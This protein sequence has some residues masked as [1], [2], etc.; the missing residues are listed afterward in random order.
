MFA[1]IDDCRRPAGR[2]RRVED[3]RPFGSVIGGASAVVIGAPGGPSHS[4]SRQRR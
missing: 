3:E 2:G 4:G 1:A